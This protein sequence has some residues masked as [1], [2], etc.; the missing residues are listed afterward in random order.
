M[1]LLIGFSLLSLLLIV[2]IAK[3]IMNMRSGKNVEEEE[4]G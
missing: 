4:A 3:A 1:T 2:E